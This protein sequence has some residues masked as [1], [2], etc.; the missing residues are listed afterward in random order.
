[1]TGCEPLG[2]GLSLPEVPRNTLPLTENKILASK[3]VCG[4]RKAR[5]ERKNRR[6]RDASSSLPVTCPHLDPAGHS[7]MRKDIL[8]VLCVKPGPT[9]PASCLL[10]RSHHWNAVGHI[11]PWKAGPSMNSSSMLSKQTEFLLELL[12]GPGP[13]CHLLILSSSNSNW[14]LICLTNLINK[15]NSNCQVRHLTHPLQ[16]HMRSMCSKCTCYARGLMEQ[17]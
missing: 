10:L 2:L 5:M 14:R 6:S 13:C 7:G 15:Y 1:M 17:A 8:G 11:S 3:R 12:G 4:F 16:M 9:L